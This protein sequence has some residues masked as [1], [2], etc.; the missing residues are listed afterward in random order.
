MASRKTTFESIVQ[1]FCAR[2][3]LYLLGA[4]ASAGLAP[5]GNGLY[6]IVAL[7]WWRNGWFSARYPFPLAARRE[8]HRIAERLPPGR[9]LGRVAS[10]RHGAFP[11]RADAGAITE[12]R[13]PTPGDA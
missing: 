12:Q 13:Y 7:D 8:D 5:L 10:S 9:N 4:G 6:R 1:H 11:G 3:G 2:R